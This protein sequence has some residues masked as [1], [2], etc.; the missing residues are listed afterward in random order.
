VAYFAAI[1]MMESIR[2][3]LE[4]TPENIALKPEIQD[5]TGDI[6]VVNIY[7]R[8][9][10]DSPLV[11]DNV[12]L[13]VRPGEFVAVVGASGSGKSTL[14]RLLLGFETPES[15]SVYY[16][17]QDIT[18][19]D[20]SSVRRPAGTVVQQARLST[21][22]I[23]TNITGM[24]NA[25]FEDAWEA[26]RAVGLDDDIRQMPME[27]Y[28]VIT[29]GISTLS[30]GQRQRIMIARAIIN[31]PRILFFDEATS[32]L[33]NKT[34]QIVSRSLE[35]LQATRVV[36]AHRL[37]TIQNADRIYVMDGGRIVETGTYAE[38]L[39]MGGKFTDLVKR[40]MVE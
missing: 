26:A 15:G 31:R 1:P 2:P 20:P 16:D 40:Q 8:Y 30:G 23:L 39:S 13:H 18:S 21:G 7:F 5:L 25:T 6:E 22:N 28:T 9:Q 11:L 29:G 35:K 19:F 14:L 33:D 32:A 38:L 12:S 34:Q 36:I 3:I 37:T 27:M 17:R 24:T 4:A 10:P